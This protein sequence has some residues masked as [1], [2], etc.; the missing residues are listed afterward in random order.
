LSLV[1]RS[2]Q[3]KRTGRGGRDS[4]LSTVTMVRPLLRHLLVCS[5]FTGVALM[6]FV[7]IMVGRAQQREVM[8]CGDAV[9]V[10]GFDSV[11]AMLECDRDQCSANQGRAVCRGAFNK[12]V[13]WCRRAQFD[14][15]MQDS[16]SS[17][18]PPSDRRQ[19]GSDALR[20]FRDCLRDASPLVIERSRRRGIIGAVLGALML[21]GRREAPTEAWQ[22]RGTPLPNIPAAPIPVPIA[23]VEAP[24][25]MLETAPIP[26]P[27]AP[28][29][30]RPQ[31]Q[32]VLTRVRSLFRA[33][34]PP[35]PKRPHGLEGASPWV[36][37][38][39]LGSFEDTAFG[40]GASRPSMRASIIGG[41]IAMASAILISLVAALRARADVHL[42]RAEATFVGSELGSIAT[43]SS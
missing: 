37:V 1:P 13:E 39:S 35:L 17:V 16:V 28:A 40:V 41:T 18:E 5:S 12:T 14:T 2:V 30:R 21:V 31:R 7:V 26:L 24:T 4:I 25:A 33:S 38:F 23:P 11:E 9:S 32:G 34:D 8:D 10:V 27:R 20:K 15:M 29:T 42:P 19:G 36:G 6:T 3:P 22:L 43:A